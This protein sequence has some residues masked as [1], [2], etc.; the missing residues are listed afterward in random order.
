MGLHQPQSIIIYVSSSNLWG[1]KCDLAQLELHSS[2]LGG[3]VICAMVF[4]ILSDPEHFIL[5]QSWKIL[6]LETRRSLLL[7]VL[8]IL[9]SLWTALKSIITRALIFPLMPITSQ[10]IG[11]FQPYWTKRE[12]VA[13]RIKTP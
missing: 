9:T 1:R 10:S 8:V 4:H 12:K 5:Q 7:T 2:A 11:Q 3:L 13:K 6:L